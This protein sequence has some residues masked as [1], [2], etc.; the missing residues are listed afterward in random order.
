M[1]WPGEERRYFE[2]TEEFVKHNIDHILEN[3][4]ENIKHQS[5]QQLK[6]SKTQDLVKNQKR[7][8]PSSTG[9]TPMKIPKSSEVLK[10]IQEV[11]NDEGEAKKETK[12]S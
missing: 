4:I 6:E 9:S 3:R 5:K 11:E 2:T 10:E 1:S 7:K 8:K 12:T